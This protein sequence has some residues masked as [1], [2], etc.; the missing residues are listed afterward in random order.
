MRN[1]E[2]ELIEVLL[3][4]GADPNS[5][6][7]DGLTPLMWAAGQGLLDPVTLLLRRGADVNAKASYGITAWQVAVGE[8][9]IRVL[10]EARR[11]P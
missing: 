6:G 7:R 3:D 1:R 4:A 11:K 10:Q 8:D 5:Q 9:V 2:P